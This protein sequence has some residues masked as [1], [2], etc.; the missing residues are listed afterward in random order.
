LDGEAILTAHCQVARLF[1]CGT[2]ELLMVSNTSVH[3]FRRPILAL[4]S[5]ACGI[6]IIFLLAAI[7]DSTEQR[8]LR[9]EADRRLEDLQSAFLRQTIEEAQTAQPLPK[10]AERVLNR[11]LKLFGEGALLTPDGW[12]KAEEITSE[13]SDFSE[14]EPILLMLGP[15]GSMGQKRVKEDEVE[16]EIYGGNDAGS[17][18]SAFRYRPPKLPYAV[19]TSY[20]FHLQFTDKHTEI[21]NDEKKTQEVSGAKQWKVQGPLKRWATVE[22]A[23]A[24]MTEKR[25]QANDAET[26][27]NIE[28]TIAILKQMSSA[29]GKACAC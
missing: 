8:R 27:K 14:Q 20:G 12:N 9:Y 26:K 2:F 17:I 19:L 22:K 25:R 3:A 18:D 24:Y 4:L 28:K 5:C 13:G 10:P 6:A 15:L 29:H 7:L 11:F 23:I 16:V 1:G 21:S